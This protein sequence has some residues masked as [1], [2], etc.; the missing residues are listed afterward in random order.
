MTAFPHSPRIPLST[1]SRLP[2]LPP[3]SLSSCLV[4]VPGLNGDRV[5]QAERPVVAGPLQLVLRRASTFSRGPLLWAPPLGPS[6]G[7]RTL[8]CLCCTTVSRSRDAAEKVMS[9]LFRVVEKDAAVRKTPEV[10]D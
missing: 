8:V 2:T 1:L 6:P 4:G 10:T 7:A 9:V 3:L 5:Q